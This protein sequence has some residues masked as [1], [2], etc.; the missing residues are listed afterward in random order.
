L[1][2]PYKSYHLDYDAAAKKSFFLLTAALA[3]IRIHNRESDHPSKALTQFVSLGGPGYDRRNGLDEDTLMLRFWFWMLALALMTTQAQ[4]PTPPETLTRAIEAL[5]AQLGTRY[6]S[7]DF[8]AITWTEMQFSDSSLGCP[9]P[10]LMYLQVITPGYQ[11]TLTVDGKSYD[12]RTNRQGTT[13]VVCGAPALGN[14][15][16]INPSTVTRLIDAGQLGIAEPLIGNLAWAGQTLILARDPN[17]ILL[18]PT[19][20]ETTLPEVIAPETAIRVLATFTDEQDRVY[21]AFGTTD[22]TISYQLITPVSEKP[23]SWQT[24]QPIHVLALGTNLIASGTSSGVQLWDPTTGDLLGEI[25]TPFEV[26]ALALS[27]QAGE[28]SLAI[29]LIT[30]AIERYQ[31]TF[32]PEIT[33]EALEPL[34]GHEQ[35][36]SDLAFALDGAILVS[37]S[38]DGTARVWDLL[39]FISPV[40]LSTPENTPMNQIAINYA[41]DL[42]LLGDDS[43]QIHVWSL[44]APSDPQLIQTFPA[45]GV[46]IVGLAFAP[47]DTLIVSGGSD[48]IIRLWG[49]GASVEQGAITR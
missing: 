10:G 31:V 15:N 9:Q 37:G 39:G 21:L 28:L 44:I 34:E 19:G 1:G 47:D 30:G 42:L 2:F 48:G 8:S 29:G 38:S 46:A 27:E 45:H 32:E 17:G 14:P 6:L 26:T 25:P 3:A 33:I 7:A 23:I 36:I 5:N 35:A 22:G 41:G 13:A 43:G 11:F 16:T 4:T 49:L 18:Y 40:V 20:T 24:E 12:V